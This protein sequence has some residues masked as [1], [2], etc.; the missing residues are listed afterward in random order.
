M[1]NG[2]ELQNIVVRGGSSDIA[3]ALTK[4]LCLADAHT[5]IL[6]GRNQM[7]LDAATL[8]AQEYG[9]TRTDTVLIDAED[10]SNA[11]SAV[12]EAF[13]K[14]GDPVDLVVM[15]V[16]MVGRQ[17]EDENDSLESARMMTVNV[18]SPVTALAGHGPRRSRPSPKSA[19]D[20]S[21]KAAVGSSS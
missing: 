11:A 1:G 14:A 10:P 17:F 7:L 19:G 2:D 21:P 20:S 12:S 13:E 8:E 5:V 4:K 18:T 15:A 9:A 3:R 6:A 16:G